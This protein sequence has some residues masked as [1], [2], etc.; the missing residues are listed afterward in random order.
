ML[1]ANN[2]TRE[3]GQFMGDQACYVKIAY[4]FVA[5]QPDVEK[6]I[7]SMSPGNEMAFI[8]QKFIDDPRGDGSLPPCE[9]IYDNWNPGDNEIR[10][11]N[12]N[13]WRKERQ[14]EGRPFDHYRELYLRIHGAQRQATLCG[15]ERGLGRKNIFEYVFYGQEN[16][17]DSCEGADWYDDTLIAHPPHRPTRDVYISPHCKTQGNV[18]FTFDFWSHVVHKLIDAGLSVTVGYDGFFCEDLLRHHLFKKHWGTHKEW[19][20]QVCA[21]KIVACGNTGT[22]WLAA[23]CGVPL[24]TMEPPNS[25]MPDHRYRQCGLRN[26]VEVMDVPD[27]DYCARRLIEEVQRVVVLTTGCYDVLHAGHV[28]H[29]ERAKALGTRLVVAMNSDESIRR[30]KGTV[31]GVRRPVNPENQ[32]KAVL[33]ALRCVDEVRTFAGPDATDL[34]RELKP[35]ILAAGFGYT[36]ETIVGREIVEEYGGRVVVTCSGDASDE[37]STTKVVKR[38]RAADIIEVCRVAEQYS[39]NPFDKLK[40]MADQFLKVAHLSGDL[41]DLGTCRG[42][43]AL[44]LRKLAPDKHL[45]MFDTW[46]GTPFDDDLCHHKKGEWAADLEECKRL[47][48]PEGKLT[49][50]L[51]GVFPYSTGGGTPVSAIHPVKEDRSLVEAAVF[52][53]VYI[54][55]DTYQTVRD[56]IAFFWPRMVPGGMM[57][58]DDYGWEPCAG[59]KKAVDEAFGER[60]RTVF[61][62]YNTCVVVKS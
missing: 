8:W 23:A 7:I 54:D 36:T 11:V 17:P 24:L 2:A 1:I 59:V 44:V 6:V 12:W 51:Q 58:F 52:C 43:T 34:I 19:M 31:D 35:Q 56:A 33:Q 26:I 21:H 40:L 38:L 32:R 29:L 22:G 5:N 49:H 27:A 4:L 47:V 45:H 3:N 55:P 50:Y 46:V 20:D 18:T 28:R 39:V 13:R 37:P 62:Q 30:L 15:Y 60:Q 25:Q 61:A 53:F 48:G 57:F 9:V 16:K 41:A 42:G 14:I 10:W